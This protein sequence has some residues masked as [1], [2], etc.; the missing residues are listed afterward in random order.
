MHFY[1]FVEAVSDSYLSLIGELR[2]L[3]LLRE[4]LLYE[5]QGGVTVFNDVFEDDAEV[6]GQE[7]EVFFD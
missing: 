4:L 6:F 3:S 2:L 7:F 5:F 1:A